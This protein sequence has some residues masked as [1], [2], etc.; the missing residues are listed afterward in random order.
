MISCKQCAVVFE[1]PHFN[2]RYCAACGTSQAASLRTRTKHAEAIKERKRAYVEANKKAVATQQKRWRDNNPE[3]AKE[4]QRRRYLANRQVRIDRAKAWNKAHPENK[5]H[6]EARRRARKRNAMSIPFTQSELGERLSMFAG[7]WICG[8]SQQAI[9]HV[10]PLAK[11]GAHILANLRPICQSC[12]SSKGAR[13]PL[14]KVR[15]I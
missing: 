2:T 9:D 3:R 6:R 8:G 15:V 14:S 12:N 1:P 5:V 4:G 13:W 7:C 11:G 10:K